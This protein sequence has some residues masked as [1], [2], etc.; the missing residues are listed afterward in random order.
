MGELVSGEVDTID[1]FVLTERTITA[2]KIV[3]HTITA[4]EIAAR[5][6]F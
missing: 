4:N 1:G 6:C 2:D 5:V 3:A